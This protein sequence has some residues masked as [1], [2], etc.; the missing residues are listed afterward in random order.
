MNG[1]FKRRSAHACDSPQIAGLN[2]LLPRL[3]RSADPRTECG[4]DKMNSTF[5]RF[6]SASLRG[7]IVVAALAG[8][9]AQAQP[10]HGEGDDEREAPRYEREM[11]APM[12]EHA[13][14]PPRAGVNW[15]PGHWVWRGDEWFWAAGHYVQAA[16][17]PMP[18]VVVETRPERPSPNHYWV[19]GHWGWDNDRWNWNRGDWRGH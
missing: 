19:R 13:P 17:P 1:A 12:V 5:R 15:V 14:P 2:F 6:L 3:R 10:F 18:P 7:A 11:P 8:G 4:E 9:I 16:V